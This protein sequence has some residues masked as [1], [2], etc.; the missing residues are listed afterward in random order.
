M[1]NFLNKFTNQELKDKRVIQT[2]FNRDCQSYI[3]DKIAE[4]G[5][6]QINNFE[7]VFWTKLYDCTEWFD[8]ISGKEI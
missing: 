8:N 6:T 3:K 7:F 2:L 1:S 4:L 5:D